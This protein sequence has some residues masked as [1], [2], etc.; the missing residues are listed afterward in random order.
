MWLLTLVGLAAASSPLDLA[1]PPGLRGWSRFAWDPTWTLAFGAGHPLPTGGRV[2]R[3]EAH[4]EAVL[5]IVLLP[6]FNSGALWAGASGRLGGGGFGLDLGA[7]TGLIRAESELGRQLGWSVDLWARPGLHGRVGDLAL[8]VGLRQGLA[9]HLHHSAAVHDLYGDRYPEGG[10]T[11]AVTGPTDG[12]FRAPVERLRVG[13]LGGKLLGDHLGLSGG[14]GWEWTPQEQGIPSNP[15]IGQ[16][17]FTVRLDL[18]L[19]W[20]PD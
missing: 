2:E 16:L 4:A 17:P 9:T 8:D 7:D 12:W 10:P 14:G 15:S 13:V 19:R 5:P 20:P 1:R 11:G 18:E 3:L 6:A